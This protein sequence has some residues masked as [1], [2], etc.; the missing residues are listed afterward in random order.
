MSGPDAEPPFKRHGTYYL[1]LKLAVL[2][3][4]LVLAARWIGLW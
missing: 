4:A 2:A 3:A 1:V